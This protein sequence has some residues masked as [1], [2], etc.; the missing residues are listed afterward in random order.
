VKYENEYSLVSVVT[1]I[2]QESYQKGL[3]FD[4][5]EMINR[6][7][8]FWESFVDV[9]DNSPNP[10]K[11][12]MMLHGVLVSVYYDP[13]YLPFE[14]EEE[15]NQFVYQMFTIFH[16]VWC[17]Y[18][19]FPYTTFEFLFLPELDW[20]WGNYLNM[21]TNAGIAFSSNVLKDH[22]FR[23]SMYAHSV[24]ESL[25][26][27]T[28]FFDF[29]PNAVWISKAMG[30][31]IADNVTN[32]TPLDPTFHAEECIINN[33]DIPL[34]E[35]YDLYHEDNDFS[36][37]RYLYVKARP[38]YRMIMNRYV[39]NT[40]KEA[41][42]FFSELYKKLLLENPNFDPKNIESLPLSILLADFQK[43]LGNIIQDK[44]YINTLFDKYV[45]NGQ[46]Y[47][48]WNPGIFTSKI[49]PQIYPLFSHE[50]KLNQLRDSLVDIMSKENQFE[51]IK[52]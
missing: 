28:F 6:L 7:F 8:P 11:K 31:N 37:F 50:E 16:Q 29:T 49:I 13:Q 15:K 26:P 40:G 22:K 39:E 5:R 19:G 43:I 44:E 41:K 24:N 52:F 12:S 34:A 20:E 2:S 23:P 46:A 36:C 38:M 1:P 21:E 42:T 33:S 47:D 9:I 4:G 25:F 10:T 35:A 32:D 51:G 27:Y 48:D 14:T 30:E 17:H 3:F 45:Y 18:Q